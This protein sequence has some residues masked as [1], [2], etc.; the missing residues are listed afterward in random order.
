[1]REKRVAAVPSVATL[2]RLINREHLFFRPDTGRRKK[3]AQ[4]AHKAHER[5]RKPYNLKADGARHI[6]EFD[7]KH[8]YLLGQK[9]YAFCAID[10]C[11]KEAVLHIASSPSSR[12]ARAA[13]VKVVERFGKDIVIVNDNGSENMKE[14]EVFLRENTITQYWTRPKSP[15]E[16]PFVERFIGTFQRECLDYHYEPMNVTELAEVVD[17]WLDKYHFYRPHESLKFL[18]PAEYCA[19]LGVTIPHVA[20]IHGE[21]SYM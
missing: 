12:N 6:V 21:V 3:H 9:H 10:P 18:T 17:A 16:K 4:S 1:L 5:L 11:T 2:G 20:A 19:T 15:K 13:L 14:A 8:V 7:M